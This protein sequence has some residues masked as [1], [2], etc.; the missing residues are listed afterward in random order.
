MPCRTP[1]PSMALLTDGKYLAATS[2]TAEPI[3]LV[4]K[5]PEEQPPPLM[6]KAESVVSKTPQQPSHPPPSLSAPPKARPINKQ[7]AP[8]TAIGARVIPKPPQN[9]KA[10]PATPKP[11][12]VSAPPPDKAAAPA[13]RK[14]VVVPPRKAIVVAPPCKNPLPPAPPVP[15]PPPM[16][17]H[18]MML[19]NYPTL[20][21][22]QQAFVMGKGL[23]L[24]MSPPVP[25]VPAAPPIPSEILGYHII[26]IMD[27]RSG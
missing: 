18:P 9:K 6:A 13:M 16:T 8:P 17:E 1:S 15:P 21:L 22:P 12:V 3:R 5:Q 23:A 14:P 26:I 20:S 25:P 27:C 11:I 19:P 10:A 24:P 7:A 2:K 4:P